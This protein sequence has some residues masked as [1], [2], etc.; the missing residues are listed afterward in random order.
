MRFIP[1]SVHG[2]IDYVWSLIL[3]ASPWVF[4]FSDGSAA[5]WIP[6]LFGVVG[7]L[8]SLGTDYELGV[9]PLLSM[10]AHLAIDLAAGVAL[11]ALP[12]LF[13]FAGRVFWPHLAFGVFAVIASL[14]TQTRPTRVDKIASARV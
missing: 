2:L 12:W 13:G 10:K 8:Y 14:V 6:V 4:G 1:T 7:I 3:L 11:A 9:A 5:T